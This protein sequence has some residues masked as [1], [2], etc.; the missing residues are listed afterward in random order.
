MLELTVDNEQLIK[1]LKAAALHYTKEGFA[2]VPISPGAKTP[3]I[4]S[5]TKMSFQSYADIERWWGA[6]TLNNMGIR[7]GAASRR[8]IVIDI[9]VA[10]G[11]FASL[12]IIES[13]HGE[14]PDTVRVQTPTGGMH[15][16]LRVPDG[17]AIPRNSAGKLAPGI[18]IRGEGGQVLAPP[19]R[20]QQGEYLVYDSEDDFIMADKICLAPLWLMELMTRADKRNSNI[21]IVGAPIGDGKNTPRLVMQGSRHQAMV[22]LVGSLRS[23]GLADDS[24]YAACTEENKLRFVPPLPDSEVVSVVGS[25]QE[26]T[27][28]PA[29]TTQWQESLQL[30][31][32]G[33]ILGTASNALLF[34]RN[35]PRLAHMYKLNLM[36]NAIELTDA[37]PWR[38]SSELRLFNGRELTDM[39]AWMADRQRF[40]Y[41]MREVSANGLSDAVRCHAES[42]PYHPVQEYLTGIQWDGTE[43]INTFF[44]DFCSTRQDA[45]VAWGAQIVFLGAVARALKPGCQHRLVPILIGKE[46]TGKSRLIHALTKGRWSGVLSRDMAM[47][48]SLMQLG[49]HWLIELS[50]LDSLK[51]T[52]ELSTIKD[53]ISRV[54]DTYRP[55]YGRIE[56]MSTRKRSCVFIGTCND[57]APLSEGEQ[58]TR[59]VPIRVGDIDHNALV[60]ETIDQLWAE[61]VSRIGNNEEWWEPTK[62]AESEWNE[63]RERATSVDPWTELVVTYVDTQ[64]ATGAEVVTVGEIWRDAFATGS[65]N[66]TDMTRLSRREEMRIA[67][68]LKRNGYKRRQQ[69]VAGRRVWGY[70][71]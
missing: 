26:W 20:R 13:T 29:Y 28:E 35:D 1:K 60:D 31:R 50:E 18:D 12:E 69:Q 67:S 45:L 56:D 34:I 37:P 11:G 5:W 47:T 36:T 58:N 8:T 32:D 2:L 52:R 21:G 55:P 64:L 3:I 63:A 38:K 57:D 42:Y 49:K 7:T 6:K 41:N 33:V 4:K 40:G 15:I 53:F 16:Y 51:R 44:S 22:K 59:F 24:I 65:N 19:S 66:K 14:L 68:V 27:A 25:T 54:D 46:W 39:R 9:D 61:A 62:E 70:C 17:M 48:D 71:H 30:G 43:R 10:T 23:R